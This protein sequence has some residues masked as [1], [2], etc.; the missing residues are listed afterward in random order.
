MLFRST[1]PLPDDLFV[2][3]YVL[4]NDLVCGDWC[5]L[6]WDQ[7]VSL[8]PSLVSST[9]REFDV[10]FSA[11]PEPINIR[12][13]IEI[14]CAYSM[15]VTKDIGVGCGNNIV[16]LSDGLQP[17][18]LNNPEA[19]IHISYVVDTGDCAEGLYPHVI[20]LKPVV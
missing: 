14:L 15:M 8:S 11:F 13:T 12:I 6:I 3:E 18:D 10:I 9:Q 17:I 16:I 7:P 19:E 2:G 20:R 5:Y 1:C 4:I